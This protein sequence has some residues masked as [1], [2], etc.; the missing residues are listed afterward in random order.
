MHTGGPGSGKTELAKLLAESLRR[1][2]ISVG[3]LLREEAEKDTE[4][5][6]DVATAIHSGTL[7]DQVQCVFVTLLIENFRSEY[8]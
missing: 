2:H 5:G 1:T 8:K 7:V 4:R 3:Q 6:Q